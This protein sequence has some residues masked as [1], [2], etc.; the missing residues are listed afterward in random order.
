MQQQ[1]TK[2]KWV[3]VLQ[4]DAH[5]SA[6]TGREGSLEEGTCANHMRFAGYADEERSQ[7]FSVMGEP[8]SLH[9]TF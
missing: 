1:L 2:T 6:Q 8:S 7:L 3:W 5:N 9:D 4:C